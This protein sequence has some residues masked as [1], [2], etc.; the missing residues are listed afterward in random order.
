MIFDIVTIFPGLFTG[1]LEEGIIRRA[2]ADR[3]V[4][5]H[6]HNIRDFALDRQRTTDDRPFGGGEGMV[7]KPEPLV[8][9]LRQVRQTGVK[10]RVVLL[11][12]AGTRYNQ[13]KAE[14]L[15][16][17][18]RLIL[19]CG[20]YEG[21]DERFRRHHVDEEISIGDYILTGGELAAM[22]LVDSIIR[23]LPGVLGC[24]DSAEN[25]TFSC[26]LL[27]HGQYTRPRD[28]E[29]DRV[30][31]VLLS[32]DH[33]KIAA[34]RLVESV[35]LTL[36][37]RPELLRNPGFSQAEEKVLEEAGLLDELRRLG[38]RD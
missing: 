6:L 20:R 12:P 3:A 34:Y 2:V 26:G 1:P 32:G 35:R 4:Q 13:N 29:G 18:E 22:V 25:D 7:M 15:S 38:H 8:A 11:T 5:I 9:C 21:V 17:C 19:V 31:E 23:L 27:K 28:F 37:R 36:Q 16:G 10:G 30:P 33:E 14:E 24:A